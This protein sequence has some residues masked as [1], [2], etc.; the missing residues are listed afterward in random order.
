MCGICNITNAQE[1]FT[2][3]IHTNKQLVRDAIVVNGVI[4]AATDGGIFA[5]N[6]KDSTFQTYTKAEGL[7]GS[8]FTAIAKD[9]RGRIW[10]GG[11][12][13]IVDVI[14]PLDNSV[15][16][17][18]DIYLSNYINKS[19]NSL[20]I[21]GDTVFVGTDFGM[22]V[23]Q[24]STYNNLD[25]YL[26]LGSSFTANTLVS[27]C[28]YLNG[29]LYVATASGIAVQNAGSINPAAPES[30]T[31][32]NSSNG[33]NATTTYQLKVFQN[34]VIAATSS[35]LYQFTSS[36]INTSFIPALQS[37]AISSIYPQGDSLFILS[38]NTLY[39][40]YNGN[41]TVNKTLANSSSTE[42]VYLA[43][44]SYFANP[45]GLFKTTSIGTS[46][47]I[48]PNGP[49]ANQFIS[50]SV[51]SKSTVWC[52]SGK[53]V[54]GV[55]FYH[56]DGT[57]WENIN[58]TTVSGFPSNGVFDVYS[59]SDGWQYLNTWG[60]GFIKYKSP[61]NYQLFNS[62][63]TPLI[64]IAAN[65][66][67]VVISDTKL[68]S[69]GSLW[70]LVFLSAS[71]T[72]M[73]CYTKDSVWYAL[74]NYVDSTVSYQYLNLAIDNYDT[75]WYSTSS[76]L[77]FMNENGSLGKPSKY[78]FGN[79][80]DNAS[81]SDKSIT[82]LLVDKRGELWIGTNLGVYALADPSQA[83]SASA[84]SLGLDQK[85]PLRQYT[86][87]CMA[88][89][90]LNRKWIGT[91]QGLLLVSS[92]GTTVLQSFSSTNSPLITD[93]VR[94]IAIDDKSGKVY[95][96]LDAAL[97]EISTYAQKP[98]D[99]FSKLFT[100]P[101]PYILSATASPL[102]IQGLIQDS[103]I[104]IIDISGN[105]IRSIQTLG[106]NIAQWDGRNDAGNLVSS[107]VYIL[108]AYDKDGNNIGTKKV[109]VIR[110]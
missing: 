98:A 95:V 92:D 13:G 69:K 96:G 65:P 101:A 44:D 63:N 100:Y 102:T 21:S 45:N 66:A 59:G 84:S 23:I 68:D 33:F 83:L 22:T 4:W 14:N 94:A 42:I 37:S 10:V 25:S 46:S 1:I 43:S 108:V 18:Y 31:D 53:D 20:I 50:L 89:D 39:L 57:K 85:F 16:S 2:W 29:Q 88:V 49:Y 75:K 47:Y 107:G 91:S 36:G 28:A 80:S 105:L 24:A 109:A 55:G 70:S 81:I 78:I 32:Y 82:C 54:T 41:L 76:D 34:S 58:K 7:A 110:K 56:Y 73:G 99:D 72:M 12:G 38:G 67:F 6:I 51:D 52:A 15:H 103:E 5:Y 40:Y 87:N 17:I 35:G 71:T 11:E 30:W 3:K 62:T 27:D 79:L 77:Y 74:S 104:K 48:Y 86:I 106:G 26:K 97:I 93:A 90:A 60:Q 19:V 64:G 8:F 61:T 9:N